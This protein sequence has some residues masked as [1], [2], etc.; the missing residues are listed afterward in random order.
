MPASDKFY[1]LLVSLLISKLK[2]TNLFISLLLTNKK[3]QNP[4][5][6]INV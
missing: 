4:Y 5:M 3:K 6:H 2:S 1:I